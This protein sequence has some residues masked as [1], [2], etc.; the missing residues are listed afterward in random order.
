LNKATSRLHTFQKHSPPLVG[1]QALRP[2][3]KSALLHWGFAVLPSRLTQYASGT[4]AAL[5]ESHFALLLPFE[6]EEQSPG[7]FGEGVLEVQFQGAFEFQ[8]GLFLLF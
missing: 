6:I 3:E 8:F 5:R 2:T 1:K 4:S 7:F